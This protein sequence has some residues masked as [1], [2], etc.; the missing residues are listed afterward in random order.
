M[1]RATNVS[2]H[3]TDKNTRL[4]ATVLGIMLCLL[5]IGFTLYISHDA[6]S[7]SFF[8]D[9][10]GYWAGAAH[11]IGYDWSSL[12][13]MG[14]YYS[15]GY[16]FLL[17]IILK[18]AGPGVTAY[19]IA[20]SLN[21]IWEIA[22]FLLLFRLSHLLFPRTDARKRIFISAVGVFYPAWLFY[23]Q[24]SMTESLL[25]F[26]FILIC[27]LVLNYLQKPSASNML[28]LIL[29]CAYS[30]TVHMR[31]IGV[32][33]SV[34]MLFVYQLWKS[35]KDIKKSI[36]PSV[37]LLVSVVLFIL[38]YL[39]KEH[40]LSAVFT[41]MWSKSSA[42]NTY[43]G[44]WSKLYA[45]F[46]WE[47]L[48]SLL[49]G[50]CGKLGYI[51]FATFGMIIF[52][53]QQTIS[54]VKK[55]TSGLFYLWLAPAVISEILISTIYYI[56]THRSDGIFYGR[57]TDPILPV[58]LVIGLLSIAKEKKLL[59]GLL[60]SNSI[61]SVLLIIASCIVSTGEYTPFRG[62]M[63][64]LFSPFI[65]ESSA[66]LP[67]G[68]LFFQNLIHFLNSSIGVIYTICICSIVLGWIFSFISAVI[69]RHADKEHSLAIIFIILIQLFIAVYSGHEYTIPFNNAHRSNMDIFGD[70]RFDSDKIYFLKEDSRLYI[71]AMQMMGDGLNIVLITPEEF[72]QNPANYDNLL[73]Y[74]WSDYQDMLE[75]Q[76]S[77]HIQTS[78]YY[79]YYR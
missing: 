16:S 8:P 23:S 11:F 74:R 14:S 79:L 3:N 56:G 53:V 2:Q 1:S 7:F 52:W 39:M 28:I 59:T 57:Y 10:F 67:S 75:E 58:I 20:I 31:F 35:G 17:A 44:Q 15:F 45:L 71:S 70:D 66:M 22:G 4:Q 65:Y 50:L 47:G 33:L 48:L 77:E 54:E 46:S 6:I 60:I 42:P 37:A 72:E 9:E 13:S 32:W 24:M 25:S 63:A 30:Y 61:F 55:T 26:L 69:V 12:A 64:V 78:T 18:F 40:M 41:N 29:V 36:F 27:N 43:E 38:T 19:R 76:Y 68:M 62:Y 34:L 51:W 73:V 21:C 49:A 5:L